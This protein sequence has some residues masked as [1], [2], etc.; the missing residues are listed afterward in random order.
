M[1]PTDKECIRIFARQLKH[2]VRLDLITTADPQT[3]RLAAF[4]ELLNGLIPR[5]QLTTVD[6]GQTALPGIAAGSRFLFHEVPEGSALP[7]F[8]KAMAA[9]GEEETAVADGTGRELL[10]VFVAPGCPFCPR[11]VDQAVDLVAHDTRLRLEVWDAALF[12][13]KAAA[14]GVRSVPTVLLG[15]RFR[16]TGAVSAAEI[17]EA[18]EVLAKGVLGAA[19]MQ[20]MIEEGNAFEM[21]RL[22]QENGAT[23][24]AFLDLLTHPA[25]PLRLGAMAV[26]ETLAETDPRLAGGV[27][28]SLWERFGTAETAVKGDILYVIG[29]V[30][31]GRWE[32]TLAVI[33]DSAGDAE[34]RAAAA[35][36]L[37]KVRGR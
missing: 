37:A 33:V 25:L 30:G 15:M 5:L 2:P 29:E 20:R 4:C 10:Q 7:P 34:V 27:L 17:R 18:C 23:A 21:V 28:P 1:T 3:A 12:P 16:W 26:M 32:S 14:C 31:D 8:L 13:E 24:P 9:A 19:A 6:G 22:F 11:V 35:E 36:A